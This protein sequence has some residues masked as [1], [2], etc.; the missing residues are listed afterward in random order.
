MLTFINKFNKVIKKEKVKR[1]DCWVLANHDPT[2]M[3][4]TGANN[5]ASNTPTIVTSLFSLLS[6]FLR[7]PLAVI[8]VYI[9]RFLQ[10]VA[11]QNGILKSSRRIM[12]ELSFLNIRGLVAPL[13]RLWGDRPLCTWSARPFTQVAHSCRSA[14]HAGRPLMQ[15]GLLYCSANSP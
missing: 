3:P 6:A 9:P 1:N 7:V 10:S 2:A 14:S 5:R 4:S 12:L 8:S 11:C 13:A 15:V